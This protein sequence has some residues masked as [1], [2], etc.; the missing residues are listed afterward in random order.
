LL[1]A[2]DLGYIHP[3]TGDLLVAQAITIRRMLYRLKQS[4]AARENPPAPRE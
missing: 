4:L 1:L 2:T 3:K